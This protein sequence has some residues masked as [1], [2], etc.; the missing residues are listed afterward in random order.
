MIGR[1]ILLWL[2]VVLTLVL[3]PYYIIMY[4]IGRP[5]HMILIGKGMRDVVGVY[6]RTYGEIHGSFKK[7][8]FR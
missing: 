8:I 5:A 7:K 3:L 4:L 6:K 2:N 1:F